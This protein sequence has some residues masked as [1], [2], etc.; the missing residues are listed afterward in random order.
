MLLQS[1][2]GFAKCFQTHNFVGGCGCR[3]GRSRTTGGVATGA[4][5]LTARARAMHVGRGAPE[6]GGSAL[7]ALDAAAR[8]PVHFLHVP[9][10][11][12]APGAQS[13]GRATLFPRWEWRAVSVP[14]WSALP[15]RPDGLVR[16]W[17]TRKGERGQRF[18]A[19]TGSKKGPDPAGTSS[20][21]SSSAQALALR[22]GPPS[23][24]LVVHLPST[25]VS[26][27][28]PH[29]TSFPGLCRSGPRAGGR[30]GGGEGVT[31]QREGR[32][33]GLPLRAAWRS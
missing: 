9:A 7:L 32:G 13:A 10:E 21:L 26:A 6:R 24:R 25:L 23:C 33:L 4:E 12:A 22:P 30:G 20:H 28:A 15:T 3:R 27:G 31:E 14:S 18:G 2:L 29:R 17:A 11:W 1:L 16:G 8:V 5:R 19:Q